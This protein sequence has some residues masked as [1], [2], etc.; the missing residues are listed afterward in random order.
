MTEKIINTIVFEYEKA[1]AAISEKSPHAVKTREDVS[2]E[3]TKYLAQRQEFQELQMNRLREKVL[4]DTL[5]RVLG[6][7]EQQKKMLTPAAEKAIQEGIKQ[8]EKKLKG[9][10]DQN[11]NLTF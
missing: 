2:P 4:R 9:R 3:L 8:V 11:I 1:M 6:T 10:G 7:E 5:R